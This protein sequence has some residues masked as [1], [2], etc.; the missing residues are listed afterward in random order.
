MT[1]AEKFKEVFGY[2]PDTNSCLAPQKVCDKQAE[3]H[4]EDI[5]DEY[6]SKMCNDCGF[7]DWWN[8]EYKPCFVLAKEYE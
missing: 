8:K 6:S 4:L 3:L 7:K 5:E 2:A 1:N